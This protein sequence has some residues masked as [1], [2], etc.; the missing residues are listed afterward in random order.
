V[1]EIWISI[2]DDGELQTEE[3]FG[4]CGDGDAGDEQ[5]GNKKLL[6]DIGRRDSV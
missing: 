6:H 4:V 1:R 2:P 5:H 3:V